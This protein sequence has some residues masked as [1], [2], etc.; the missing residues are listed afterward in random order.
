MTIELANPIPQPEP[1]RRG[2]RRPEP[3]ADPLERCAQPRRRGWLAR[4]WAKP[5]PTALA[6]EELEEAQRQL[7]VS[8]SAQEYAANMAKYHAQRISRLRSFLREQ[9]AAPSDQI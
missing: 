7:L 5:S 2:P 8:Q 6:V 9:A 1:E 3:P 4:L